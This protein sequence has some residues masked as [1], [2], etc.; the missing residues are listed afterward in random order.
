MSAPQREPA[1]PGRQFGGYGAWLVA[2]E[3]DAIAACDGDA[4]EILNR[5]GGGAGEPDRGAGARSSGRH[6]EQLVER[7]GSG[8][9]CQVADRQR[10]GMDTVSMKVLH[11]CCPGAAVERYS[12]LQPGR[13]FLLHLFVSA[14]RPERNG[15]SGPNRFAARTFEPVE[16]GRSSCQ[17]DSERSYLDWE[18]GGGRFTRQPGQVRKEAALTRPSGFLSSL[19]LSLARQSLSSGADHVP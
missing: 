13:K 6:R 9:D 15:T 11:G 18:V 12:K 17:R 10:A 19:P 1:S 14:I 3:G 4:H 5:A 16:R 2:P 7:L 8:V